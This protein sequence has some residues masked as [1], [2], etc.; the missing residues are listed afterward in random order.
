MIGR[1]LS[2]YD[3]KQRALFKQ[4]LAILEG[5]NLARLAFTSGPHEPIKQIKAEY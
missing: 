1:I 3:Y 5:E 4:L 2:E